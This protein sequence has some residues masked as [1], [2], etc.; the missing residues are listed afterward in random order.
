MA[1]AGHPFCFRP[2]ED[3]VGEVV[4]GEAGGLDLAVSPLPEN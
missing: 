3:F 2:P 1:T 4:A